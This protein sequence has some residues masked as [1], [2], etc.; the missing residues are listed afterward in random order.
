MYLKECG[1][2]LSQMQCVDNNCNNQR[3][4]QSYCCY[5]ANANAEREARARS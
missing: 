2:F 4:E 1:E 5:Q 3:V